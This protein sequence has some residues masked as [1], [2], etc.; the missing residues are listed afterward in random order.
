[1][2]DLNVKIANTIASEERLKCHIM[3]QFCGENGSINMSEMWKV[4]KKL[5]P[6]KASSLP[7]AKLNHQGQ[8]VSTA[9]EINTTMRKEYTERLKERPI[10]P[11]MIKLYKAKNIN[12][13]QISK[14]NKNAAIT[15]EELENV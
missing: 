9:A 2:R 5:W 3:R 11:H 7:A 4:K 15:M 14:K 12:Y 10:H 13:L 6:T 1:M 8:L